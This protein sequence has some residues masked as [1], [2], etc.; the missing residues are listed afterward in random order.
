MR[1]SNAGL[2]LTLGACALV[3]A[4][5][6]GYSLIRENENPYKGDS[7]ISALDK[8]DSARKTIF[9]TRKSLE[10][11]S[12]DTHIELKAPVSM[13]VAAMDLD[14]DGKTL[15]NSEEYQR[16]LEQFNS[17]RNRNVL[18]Y[19]LA[20]VIFSSLA[21]ILAISLGTETYLDSG[22]GIKEEKNAM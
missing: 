21:G 20:G 5:S 10:S 19:E 3:G 9:S 22:R 11:F 14:S 1:R 13:S 6:S 8:I 16:R 2:L 18:P 4:G 7:Y 17:W 15:R 12:H